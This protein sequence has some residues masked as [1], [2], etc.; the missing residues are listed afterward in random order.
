MEK[1]TIAVLGSTGSVGTQ[2]LDVA[3]SLNVKVDLL[4]A[5]SQTELAEKQ[6]R[7]FSPAFFVMQKESAAKDLAVRVKD[8]ST[9]VLCGC[10]AFDEALAK[11]EAETVIH[12]VL[13][14]AGLAPALS[15]IDSGKRLGLANKECLVIAGDIVMQRAKEKNVRIIPVDSGHSAIFQSLCGGRKEEISSI[16]LTASG[17]PFFGYG[18]DRLCRVTK[19]ET[20]AHP[21][22]KMGQKITVDSADLM[23]KGCEVIEAVRLFGVSPGQIRV[24]VHRESIIHSAVEYTDSA[25]IAQLGVPDMRLCVQYAVTYPQRV[26]GPVKRLSLTD[27]GKLTFYQPDT[28]AFPLLP[29]AFRAI[30]LGGGVPAVL[31][32]ADEVAVDAFLHDRISFT[33]IAEVV[34]DTV[35]AF[36]FAKDAIKLDERVGIAEEAAGYAERLIQAG[37]C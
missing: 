29:L 1:R 20:L 27:V 26:P 19:E 36:A 8:T 22:W 14:S 34:T 6:I 37:K 25:V 5:Y 15:V 2:A 16:I 13:G 32:R 18:K 28:E 4:S 33:R 17:G 12:S 24:V 7:K 3:E 11:S 31:N 30:T 23:N 21:T 10:D 35:E 9:K